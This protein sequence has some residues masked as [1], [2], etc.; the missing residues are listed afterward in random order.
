MLSLALLAGAGCA[1]S[2]SSSALTIWHWMTDRD[3]A[4]Q[5]LARRYELETGMPVKFELY[6]PSELYSQKIRGAAQTDTLPDIFGVLG[7]SRDFASLVKAGFIGNLTPAMDQHGAAWRSRFY[8]KALEMDAFGPDN[9]YGIPAGIYGVPID[10]TTIQLVYNKRLFQRAGLNPKSFPRTWA[11]L[12]DA[13]RKLKA[14]GIPTFVSGW[15]ETWLL[16]CFASNYAWNLMGRDKVLATI[17]GEV[18]Y[19]DPDWIRVLRLFVELRDGGLLYDGVVTMVNK[20][21]EQ[22]FANEGAAIALNGSWCVNV[23]QGM[24]PD[25]EYGVALPPALSD[26]YPV[27]IW[28][29]AGSSFM[30]NA[31]TP[32]R[33]PAIRFLQWLT[34]TAQQQFLV[35]ATHNLPSTH[36]A[37]LTIPAQLAPFADGMEHA[38]HPSTLPVQ[39]LAPVVEAWGKGIQAIL[40]GERTP[41][42]VAQKVQQVKEREL[43]R[44]RK[45]QKG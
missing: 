34:A 43:A 6:A 7:E 35:E 40:I 3:E 39:E 28:G 38:V 33:E 26:Q 31:R 9:G 10:V 5:S 25:L 24:N 42:Q 1:P 8:A 19:T 13:G 29:G 16:D 30:V 21:A 45:Q 4:F 23:Y 14:A 15:G 41:E 11:E 36:A 18:P 22:V 44:Q 20:R 2:S 37:A 17:R 32:R 12:L 27:V